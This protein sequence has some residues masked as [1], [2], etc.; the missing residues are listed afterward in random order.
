MDELFTLPRGWIPW[1]SCSATMRFITGCV[2]VWNVST[3]N[4][5]CTLM[6]ESGEPP[7]STELINRWMN[8]ELQVDI[9]LWKCWSVSGYVL[10]FGS[11]V[12]LVQP[13]SVYNLTALI[14][15]TAAM[16]CRKQQ[17]AVSSARISPNPCRT[18]RLS[19]RLSSLKRSQFE[20]TLNDSWGLSSRLAAVIFS[21]P[22]SAFHHGRSV[23]IISKWTRINW[24][25]N[26]LWIT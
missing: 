15:G 14:L 22:P 16:A 18:E 7:A 6:D 24:E 9:S 19:S 4:L 13:D 17:T 26:I 5:V 2:S 12:S 23:L 20:R 25:K 10:C 21:V 8:C 11:F 1:L 3:L